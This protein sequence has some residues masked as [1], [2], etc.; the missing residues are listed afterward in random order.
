MIKWGMVCMSEKKKS[1]EDYLEAI[2]TILRSQGFCR[3]VDICRQLNFSRP[4]V[5]IAVA[6]LEESNLIERTSN[7]YIAL[8]EQ[9]MSIAESTWGKH[10]LLVNILK[11]IGVEEKIA[12][13]DACLIEH[14]ISDE[15]FEKLKIWYKNRRN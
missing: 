4:S 15:T 2:F 7:G 6:K 3:S 12:E 5:S 11:S 14:Q 1:T 13:Q 8:T 10:C 9:G